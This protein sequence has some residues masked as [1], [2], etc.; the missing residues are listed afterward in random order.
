MNDAATTTTSTTV[1]DDIARIERRMNDRRAA[2]REHFADARVGAERAARRSRPVHVGGMLA[3][4][5]AIGY[6]IATRP[7]RT[8]R[9]ASGLWRKAREAPEAARAAVHEATRPP[10]KVWTE[11][12]AAG[13]GFALAVMRALPQLRALAAA[14]PRSERRR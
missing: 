10:S 13:T 2:I 12:L 5:L 11:R 9:S 1:T 4:A 7:S 8:E 3:G 14:M 6:A